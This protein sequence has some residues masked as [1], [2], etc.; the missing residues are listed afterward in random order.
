MG[1]AAGH[2]RVEGWLTPPNVPVASLRM[3]ANLR[4]GWPV[5]PAGYFRFAAPL[6]ARD[7]D[8]WLPTAIDAPVLLVDVDPDSPERGQ[9]HPVVAHTL[10][11]DVYSPDY[12]LAVAGVP[13]VILAPRRTYAFVLRRSL[14][15]AAGD[16]LGVPL[17]M[18]QLRAGETPAGERGAL[19]ARLYE[20]LWE[21]LDELGVPRDEVAAATVFTTGDVVADLAELSDALLGRHPVAIEDLAVD[22]SDGLAHE[23]FCELHGR[24]RLPQFQRGTPP[25]NTGGLFEIGADGLPVVQREEDAPLALTIPREPMPPAGYPLVHYFHGTGG[26]AT[27][28]VDRGP[29][30]EPRGVPRAGLGPAHVVAAHGFAAAGSASPLNPERP[31]FMGGRTYLNLQNL[32]AYPDTFRQG[33]IEQRLLLEALSQLEIDPALL[34]GCAGASLPEGATAFRFD[35][36][37]TVA[38]GQSL[39]GQFVNMVGAVEPRIAAA[40]PTSSGGHWSRVVLDGEIAPGANNQILIGL[41]LSTNVPLTY[42][43]PGLQLVQLAYEPA[44]PIVFAPRLAR[45]PLPGHPVRSIYQPIG[46]DDPGFPNWIY[47]AMALASGSQQAGEILWTSLQSTLAE[48]DRAGIAPYPVADNQLSAAGIPYTGVAVQYARDEFLDSHHVFAQLDAVKFQYGC[49]LATLRDT[50]V[51][52]VPAPAPLGSPCS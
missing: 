48:E 34:A 39:G 31:P 36:A 17:A 45:D 18:A 10:P 29:V 20:P 24:I 42:L 35:T 30:T 47:D 7:L 8:D 23:R 25:F 3:L 41:V 6:A 40:I 49:F 37:R 28:V 43:H 13:G 46:L 52:V 1:V 26:L 11:S 21:T 4:R 12:L 38:M 9:L 19:A 15:D 22:P 27:Q 16:L 32:T 14:G 5:T 2:P 50:G 44:E 33:T 51:A